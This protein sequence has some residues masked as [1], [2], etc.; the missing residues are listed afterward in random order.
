[1]K[2]KKIAI[3]QRFITNYRVSFFNLLYDLLIKDNIELTIFAGKGHKSDKFKDGLEGIKCGERV[4][5]YRFFGKSIYWQN[6][7]KPLDKYDLVIVEQANSALLNY[8]LFFKRFYISSKPKLAFWGHGKTLTKNNSSISNRIK[9]SLANKSDYWFGYTKKTKDVL[10]EFGVKSDK[11]SII[12]NSIEMDIINIEERLKIR[13]NKKIVFCSRLYKDKKIPFII[14]SCKIVKKTVTDLELV[15]IGDG[16]DYNQIKELTNKY[17]W[18]KMTGALFGNDKREILKNSQAMV[19]PSS[20]GLSILDAFENGLPLITSTFNNHGPEIAY[21]EDK[22]NG[23]QTK[24]NIDDFANAIIYILKNPLILDK[25]SKAA[26]KTAEKYTIEKMA[27]NFA[28]GVKEAI[29]D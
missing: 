13:N 29:N 23:L 20:L 17:D 1:M 27:Q 25:M 22:I 5:N 14:D 3:V 4:K 18:I 2:V 15:I 10:R 9:K 6:I 7:Y 16:P 24:P 28:N 8:F 26:I 21:L 11:I 12:N 19:Q